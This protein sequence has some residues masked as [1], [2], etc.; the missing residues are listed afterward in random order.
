MFKL[1]AKEFS[2]K[3]YNG[4]RKAKS[5]R[6]HSLDC[7]SGE[8]LVNSLLPAL[9]KTSNVE[10]EFYLEFIL[11]KCIN[12]NRS[13]SDAIQ[14]LTIWLEK[15]QITL[16]SGLRNM[17]LKPF[18]NRTEYDHEGDKWY[19]PKL[20]HVFSTLVENKSV[21]ADEILNYLFQTF[22]FFSMPEIFVTEV[23]GY[24]RL[25][26]C[27]KESPASFKQALLA[28][29]NEFVDQNKTI[30]I[31]FHSRRYLNGSKIQATDTQTTEKQ[32]DPLALVSYIKNHLLIYPSIKNFNPSDSV[33]LPPASNYKWCSNY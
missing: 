10:F 6:Y 3:Y 29:I 13:F 24:D 25:E 19:F 20:L 30:D 28:K 22:D 1:S 31:G 7:Q 27:I 11:K 26:Q 14:F 17:Q 32:T 18:F 4:K 21:L 12:V 2:N 16:L 23:V 9:K 5:D 8:G 33:I 15:S